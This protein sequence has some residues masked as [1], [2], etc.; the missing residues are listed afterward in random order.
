LFAEGQR[1][2]QFHV[3]RHQA[4]RRLR[5]LEAA[6]SLQDL[7]SL[8]SNHLRRLAAIASAQGARL[9]WA[10]QHPYQQAMA[11]LF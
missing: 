10:A 9:A 1:I 4:E 2:P 3:F 8:S 7:A 11:H 5:I 6:T